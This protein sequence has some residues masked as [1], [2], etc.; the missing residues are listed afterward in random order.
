MC[1][2][3]ALHDDIRIR[4]LVDRVKRGMVKEIVIATD[5]RVEGE[6]TAAY[7]VE[8]LKPF[9][10]TVTRIASGMPAGGEVRYSDP[11]T[12]KNAM[13]KRYAL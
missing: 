1:D 7:L 12:L 11:V 10:V 6:A 8:V 5:T 13:E 2:A 9:S 4:E 3:D